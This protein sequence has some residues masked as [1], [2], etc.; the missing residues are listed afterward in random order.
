MPHGLGSGTWA[1]GQREDPDVFVMRPF[2][3][4]FNPHT[5]PEEQ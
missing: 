3:E 4:P 1:R 5:N 2:N